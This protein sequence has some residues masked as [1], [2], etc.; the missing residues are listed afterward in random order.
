[1]LLLNPTVYT[2]IYKVIFK[3]L[4][5][6]SGLSIVGVKSRVTR[7]SGKLTAV[8]RGTKS[9]AAE[10]RS[11]NDRGITMSL[12]NSCDVRRRPNGV[13]A[14]ARTEPRKTNIM[15][16]LTALRPETNWA[17]R[18]E[19]TWAAGKNGFAIR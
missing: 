2:F 15:A 4:I 6:L 11:A 17:R 1:M 19:R 3:W 10:T 12:T 16:I 9:I 8:A 5:L 7:S 13:K 18:I 14:T